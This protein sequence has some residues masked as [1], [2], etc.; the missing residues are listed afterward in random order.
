[1][2]IGNAY[3][4]CNLEPC[5]NIDIEHC[6]YG[7]ISANQSSASFSWLQHLLDVVQVN[8]TQTFAHAQ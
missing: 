7:L 1:M 6:Q 2:T 4:E 8:L 5:D 3:W